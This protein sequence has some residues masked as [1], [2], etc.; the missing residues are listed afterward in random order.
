MNNNNLV[1]KFGKYKGVHLHSMTEKKHRQY[2]EWLM[3]QE[4]FNTNKYNN[5]LVQEINLFLNGIFEN[6]DFN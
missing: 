2:L 1:F 4:W 6:N 3:L 5:K